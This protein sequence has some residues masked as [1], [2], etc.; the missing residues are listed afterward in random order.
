L[1]PKHHVPRGRKF[2]LH[3][4]GAHEPWKTQKQDKL[5]NHKTCRPIKPGVR[6]VFSVDFE[7]MDTTELQL[8]CFALMP[9]QTF[10]HKIGMGKPIGLGSIR[11]TPLAVFY[12]DHNMRYRQKD[13]FGRR[14]DAGLP[15]KYTVLESC[16]SNELDPENWPAEYQEEAELLRSATG[17]TMGRPSL[18]LAQLS[19]SFRDSM[20]PSVRNALDLLGDPKNVSKVVQYP[21]VKNAAAEGQEGYRWFNLNEKE[22]SQFLMP[23]TENSKMLPT[24]KMLDG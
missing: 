9:S 21:K 3:Q 17:L 12:I 24:L 13:P 14:G 19:K 1:S 18:S 23:L 8:L 7:N 11:I 16:E 4:I 20:E 2:Y 15:S 5:K 6:F 10:V 22:K